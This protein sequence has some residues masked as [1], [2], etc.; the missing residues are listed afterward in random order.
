ILTIVSSTLLHRSVNDQERR[1]LHERAGEVG[2]LL[3]SLGTV[4]QQLGI[5]GT[6]Y[7]TD[8]AK[9]A[10]PATAAAVNAGGRGNVAIVAT[11]GGADVVRAAAGASLP[12]GTVV[13][14]D[15]AAL[16]D[17]A[18]KAKSFVSSVVNG[19]SPNDRS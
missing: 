1:L 4:G 15:R 7:E 2:T 12:T 3:G 19:T 18:T 9:G 14:G 8:G 5:V 6:V 10:F 17:R 11:E 13:S 16:V